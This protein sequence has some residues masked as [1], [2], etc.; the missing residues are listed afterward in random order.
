ME[1]SNQQALVFRF[2]GEECVV[3]HVLSG[4]THLLPA[5]QARAL[6]MMTDGLRGEE[7][8]QCLQAE[9]SLSVDEAKELATGCYR[10]YKNLGLIDFL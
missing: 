6:Q 3:Y 7:L 1:N 2:W 8:A 9:Y 4:D 5:M 10:D